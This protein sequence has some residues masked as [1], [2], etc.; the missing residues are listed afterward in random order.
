MKS[1]FGSSPLS[2]LKN[3][4]AVLIAVPAFL[5]TSGCN[6]SM[7]PASQE[8]AISKPSVPATPID[9]ATVASIYGTVSF[10]G[11]AP[12]PQKIDMSDDPG[13]HGTNYSESYVVNDGKLANV[14]VYVKDGLDNRKFEPSA[15]PAVIDQQGC[16]YHPHMLG[17]MAGQK[18]EFKNDDPTMHNVHVMPRMNPQWNRSELEGSAPFQ[19][20]FDNPE[21]MMPIQ[22]NQHPWMKMFLNVVSNP[23]FSITARNG[24]Y[25]I[26][27]LPP[28]T[29]T[30]AFVHE[31]LGEQDQQVVVGPKERKMLNLSFKP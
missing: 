3:L 21:I 18:I 19:T 22:C 17:A 10:D 4:L 28:G 31:K 30:L 24:S 20:S 11:T 12:K 8:T 25:E 6:H 15:I 5:F 16:R 9:P 7:A 27:G 1:K 26:N 2:A 29:Y 14:F 23:F 13:C